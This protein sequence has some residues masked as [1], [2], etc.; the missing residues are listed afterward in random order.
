MIDQARED[1]RDLE[2]EARALLER[3]R[4]TA[5]AARQQLADGRDRLREYAVNRPIQA[6]GIAFGLGVILGCLIKRR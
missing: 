3:A 4:S 2:L 1:E 5:E 6:L